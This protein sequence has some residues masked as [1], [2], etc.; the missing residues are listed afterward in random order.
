MGV[1]IADHRTHSFPNAALE[2]ING[3]TN[4]TSNSSAPQAAAAT[5]T[6]RK[7]PPSAKAKLTVRSGIEWLLAAGVLEA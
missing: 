4:A 2:G 5:A 6:P 7:S 1:E 3:S